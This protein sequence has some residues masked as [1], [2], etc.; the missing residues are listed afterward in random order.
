MVL[1]TVR[2]KTVF[3]NVGRGK[4]RR[5]GWDKTRRWTYYDGKLNINRLSRAWLLGVSCSFRSRRR[6]D[7]VHLA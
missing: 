7:G 6:A 4:V 2:L 3:A 5:F 1:N